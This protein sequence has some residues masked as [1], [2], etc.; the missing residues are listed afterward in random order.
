MQRSGSFPTCV[1]TLPQSHPSLTIKKPTGR[2]VC[3]H[4]QGVE[5]TC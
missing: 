3:G 4:C 2:A 5:K 1:S